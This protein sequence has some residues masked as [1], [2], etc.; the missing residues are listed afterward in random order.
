VADIGVAIIEHGELRPRPTMPSTPKRASAGVEN[1]SAHAHGLGG[2]A[3]LTVNC[4]VRLRWVGPSLQ[5][6]VEA[7]MTK[8]ESTTTVLSLKLTPA[9][10][11]AYAWL[12]RYS[13]EGTRRNY[14]RN[15]FEWIR[16]CTDHDLDPLAATRVQIELYTRQLEARGLK[17]STIA[18]KQNALAGYY[19]YA[20]I[21]DYITKNPMD[22]VNR[23]TLPRESS[24]NGLR[25]GEMHDVLRAAE[26]KSPR[27]HALLK[28]LGLNGMRISEALGI[29]IEHLGMERGWHTV[30]ILRKGGKYQTLPL[31][32][33]TA[34][35]IDVYKGR[36]TTG[37]LFITSTGAR[38]SRNQAGTEI[39]NLCRDLGITKRI[40]PH[41]FRHAFVTLSLDA[42]A[43]IRDVQNATGHADSR[44]V[45]YYDRNR[46][47]LDK[48]PTHGLSAFIDG[49]A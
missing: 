26:D 41:S 3:S 27:L 24:T 14:E 29:D 30:R 49:M 16:W 40:S 19:R 47:S 4:S 12:M 33:P 43:T 35:A 45:S 17:R 34:W 32:P 7:D 39:R 42:G 22:H 20:V 6:E 10:E 44:M 38:L 8:I 11:C 9:E 28:L 25:R 23:V 48:N 2:I 1:Y 5:H 13:N 37:P 21:D 46:E 18:G 15:I 36:R 31:A